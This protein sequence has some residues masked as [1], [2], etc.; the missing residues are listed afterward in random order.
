MKHELLNNHR[1]SVAVAKAVVDPGRPVFK[2]P[3]FQATVGLNGAVAMQHLQM[4]LCD[5]EEEAVLSTLRFFKALAMK[6]HKL[7]LDNGLTQV[8][9]DEL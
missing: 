5:T 4:E 9:W 2:S 3:S 8:T 6:A 1:L 7:A